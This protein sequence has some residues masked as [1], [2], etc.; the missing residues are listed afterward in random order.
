[1]TKVQI[2]FV[3][4]QDMLADIACEF[5]SGLQL[6]CKTLSPLIDNIRPL[7]A[8]SFRDQS[9]TFG[10]SGG[11]KLHKLH[12]ADPRP[13][14]KCGGYHIATALLWVGGMPSIYSGIS[15]PSKH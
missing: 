8:R 6:L 5:I 10:K 1:M 9:P 3:S 13:R 12:I 11:V 15:T 4:S 14:A 2:N 7:A